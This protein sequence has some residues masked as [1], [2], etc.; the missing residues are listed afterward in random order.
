MDMLRRPRPMW[1][2]NLVWPLVALFA[3]PLAIWLYRRVQRPGSKPSWVRVATATC[4]CGAGCSLG[5]ILAECLMVA[6]PGLTAALGGPPAGGWLVDTAVAYLLGIGFQYFTIAPMRGLGLKAGLEA[7][8]KADTLSLLAWQ[9]GM[10][11]VMAAIQFGVARLTPQQPEFWFAM[12]G[13]MLAG[14]ALSYPVNAW[15]LRKGLKEPM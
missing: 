8:W 13:A 12:Q 2:M 9:A 14:F 1:I 3:G 6:A 10:I 11:G 15:L 7:A 4:H 5:D